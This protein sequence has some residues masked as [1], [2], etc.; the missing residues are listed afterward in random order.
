ML[1]SVG[2]ALEQLE[3]MPLSHATTSLLTLEH[4]WHAPLPPLA[5]GMRRHLHKTE[6]QSGLSRP[7]KGSYQSKSTTIWPFRTDCLIL[8]WGEAGWGE[9][10]RM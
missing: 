5:V 9:R 6:V 8:A 2:A 10:E 7:E 1:V 4:S 3:L